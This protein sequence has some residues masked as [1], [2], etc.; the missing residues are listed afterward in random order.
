MQKWGP[1]LFLSIFVVVFGGGACYMLWQEFSARTGAV[2]V[3][4]RAIDFV[5]SQDSDGDASYRPVVEYHYGD[6]PQ[7]HQVTAKV[8]TSPAAP[9]GSV[10]T[11]YVRPEQPAN[12][13][14][15]SFAQSWLLPL[16]F[17]FFGV[18]ASIAMV[19][20]LRQA[21]TPDSAAPRRPRR[22]ERVEQVLAATAQT[23][24]AS[25]SAPARI[26]YSAGHRGQA[27]STLVLTLFG[28]IFG[29]IG[30]AMAWP[31]ISARRGAIELS[32]TVV[33]LIR[34]RGSKGGTLYTPVVE[35]H[36]GPGE[37][38][39]SYRVRGRVASSSAPEL[40]ERLPVFV[41]PETPELGKLG[42]LVESWLFPLVFGGVGLAMLSVLSLL[43]LR[44]MR[45]A[46]VARYLKDHGMPIQASL[47]QVEFKTNVQVNRQSPWV[48]H[49]SWRHPLSGV[50]HRFTS[51]WLWH[52]PSDALQRLGHVPMLVDADQPDRYHHFC[53][54]RLE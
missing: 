9:L 14:V 35:Y 19:S 52:D 36:Y 2:A 32:G 41:K 49:A 54:D 25:V 34:S 6:P 53:L 29:G 23:A 24:S 7:R 39:A 26:D 46:R 48:I 44:R 18:A 8:G 1:A 3:K 12:G 38:A 50:E 5:V 40:G 37:A 20:S 15:S 10:Y 4:G 42:G 45:R 22:V 33:E 28:L 27:L 51:H 43:S 47:I 11:V 17:G 16:V 21:P 13:H 30:A 31:E